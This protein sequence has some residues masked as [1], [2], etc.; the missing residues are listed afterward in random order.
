[1]SL[2]NQNFVDY[3]FQVGFG[4]NVVLESIKIPLKKLAESDS[5][6]G[7]LQ[8][9]SSASKKRTSISDDSIILTK[10]SKNLYRAPVFKLTTHP[11][12]Y[13]YKPQIS[14][15]YPE[16]NHSEQL[17]FPSNI[18]MFCYPN[19]I[20]F[21]NSL[22]GPPPA[23]YHSFII[24]E[25][26]GTK[27]YGVCVTIYEKVQQNLLLQLEDAI[28]KWKEE[29]A[30]SIAFEYITG[31][32]P[33]IDYERETIAEARKNNDPDLKEIEESA[34]ERIHFFNNLMRPYQDTLL[35]DKENIFEPK[36]IG[37]T[38][39]WPWH[40][41]LKD[42]LCELVRLTKESYHQNSPVLIAPIERYIV[43]LIYEIP[44]PPP[45]KLEVSISIGKTKLYCSRPPVN[46]ISVVQNMSFYPLFR[47]LSIPHIV[48]LFELLIAEKKIIFVSNYLSMLTLASE[49]MCIFFYPMQWQHILIPVLPANLLQY[50]QAPVPYMVGLQ[51]DYFTL[52]DQLEYCPSDAA[53]IDLDNDILAVKENPPQLPKKEREKLIKNLQKYA[54]I[55]TLN[56][57][58]ESSPIG[59]DVVTSSPSISKS[60]V[61]EKEE[62]KSMD[63]IPITVREAFPLGINLVGSSNLNQPPSQESLH[64]GVLFNF[65]TNLGSGWVNTADSSTT[66]K[67]AITATNSTEKDTG[68]SLL[69]KFTLSRLNLNLPKNSPLN[70]PLGSTFS[71][72]ASSQLLNHSASAVNSTILINTSSISSNNTGVTES[73]GQNIVANESN[74]E[75]REISPAKSLASAVSDSST[76]SNATPIADAPASPRKNAFASFFSRRSSAANT[77]LPESTKVNKNFSSQD[78]LTQLAT[79][80][81][82]PHNRK[83]TVSTTSSLTTNKTVQTNANKKRLGGK[84]S[85]THTPVSMD[86]DQDSISEFSGS[87]YDDSYQSL[88]FCFNQHKGGHNFRC[89]SETKEA[90]IDQCSESRTQSNENI[91]STTSTIPPAMSFLEINT[92][93]SQ[94]ICSFCKSEILLESHVFYHCNECNIT[95]HESCF[96]LVDGR[97]CAKKFKERKIQLSF[98]KFFTSVLKDY[99]KFIVEANIES[100][101]D[102]SQWFKKSEYLKTF[103]DKDNSKTF[104]SSLVETQAF[105]QFIY[106]RVQRSKSDYEVL[107]FDESIKAKL[108]RSSFRVSKE[109]TPFLEDQSYQVTQTYN[110][111]E[112]N[113]IDLEKDKCYYQGTFPVTLNP[114]YLVIPKAIKPLLTESDQR[115]MQSRTNELIQ[116]SAVVNN[117][118]GKVD[119]GYWMKNKFFKGAEGIGKRD[120]YNAKILEVLEIAEKYQ[121]TLTSTQTKEELTAAIQVLHEKNFMLLNIIDDEQIVGENEVALIKFVC[122]KLCDT[123][124]NYEETNNKMLFSPVSMETP[125][126][127][128]MAA[129][130]K[131]SIYPFQASFSKLEEDKDEEITGDLHTPNETRSTSVVG[132]QEYKMS[133]DGLNTTGLLLK[134]MI[135]SKNINTNEGE[136]NVL[137]SGTSLEKVIIPTVATKVEGENYTEITIEGEKKI[138][139][140]ITPQ[141]RALHMIGRKLTMSSH[142]LDAATSPLISS[143]S[144][145]FRSNSIQ[146]INS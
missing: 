113:L 24:T 127:L 139:S 120:S 78:L 34:Q 32:G 58:P 45:G 44:L 63:R 123:V 144:L 130:N 5:F 26:M 146:K 40:D 129:N 30:P 77:S 122:A 43:N 68:S 2:V 99:R 116:R 67:V 136:R 21:V 131:S 135:D 46:N 33:K 16:I 145:L 4:A 47:A 18:S 119:F 106:E 117:S 87:F 82:K 118:K 71:L 84:I 125:N 14:M 96:S 101:D 115:M 111:L 36:T 92:T 124:S 75:I 91:H 9:P 20:K 108:N 73:L 121:R 143:K 138:D 104:M 37:V 88:S 3:F 141:P 50:L 12:E 11:I 102:F 6:I 54:D 7:N 134:E 132:K 15:R 69:K 90:G 133:M 1:M 60:K 53:L 66:P 100:N 114:E 23:T 38:S 52:E 105:S 42:W 48:T 8:R 64:S 22:S 72:S 76:S 56:L 137:P 103:K 128:Q 98:F 109:T 49:T 107:F 85:K 142:S 110:S 10:T 19:D 13:R 61:I 57:I 27:I 17:P 80:K 93:D 59:A 35:L 31:L 70:S 81:E 51:R 86:C 65:P 140:T 94:K 74:L 95:I 29:N 62:A 97:P 89:M 39:H 79:L 112:P 83:L 25:G 41:L 28:A 126:Y 55:S